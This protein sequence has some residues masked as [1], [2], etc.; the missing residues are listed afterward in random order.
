MLY[1]CL[2]FPFVFSFGNKTSLATSASTFS[3]FSFYTLIKHIKTKLLWD[4]KIKKHNVTSR[5]SSCLALLF[6]ML[7]IHVFCLSSRSVASLISL[8]CLTCV[9]LPVL[10]THTGFL[11][12]VH[13]LVY[14]NPYVCIIT[15]PDCNVSSSFFPSFIWLSVPYFGPFCILRLSF[16]GLSFFLRSDL[17][18]PK[19]AWTFTFYFWMLDFPL[20][21]YSIGLLVVFELSF[22][23]LAMLLL[24]PAVPV[25]WWWTS[26]LLLW[27]KSTYSANSLV[28]IGF[29]VSHPDTQNQTTFTNVVTCDLNDFGIELCLRVWLAFGAFVNRHDICALYRHH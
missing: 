24:T 10:R 1:C 3:H 29:S 12:S 25:C 20:Y 16:P 28:A 11:I 17:L 14:T 2:L 22:L 21:L 23:T 9:S 18:L 8:I 15:L 13:L 7:C 26:E 6:F 5:V 4:D 27:I 19:F